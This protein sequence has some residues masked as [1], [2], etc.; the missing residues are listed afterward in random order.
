MSITTVRAFATSPAAVVWLDMLG[1]TLRWPF[2][3]RIHRP[4]RRKGKQLAIVEI[5]LGGSQHPNMTF[6]AVAFQR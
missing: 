6:E 2:V 1:A 3:H 4:I 5:I